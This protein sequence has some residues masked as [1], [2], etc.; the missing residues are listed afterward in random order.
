[1]AK[2][3]NQLQKQPSWDRGV[4]KIPNEI[5]LDKILFKMRLETIYVIITIKLMIYK[6]PYTFLFL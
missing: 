2:Y 4:S 6:S 5:D 1:M 3:P